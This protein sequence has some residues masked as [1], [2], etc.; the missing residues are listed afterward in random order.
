MSIFSSIKDKIFGHKEESVATPA[1]SAAAPVAVAEAAPIAVAPITPPAIE[2]DVAEVVAHMAAQHN[3]SLNWD[4]SI[5]DLMK[6]LN[7]DSSLTNRKEL[8]QELG[9]LGQLDGSADMNLWLHKQVMTE[10]AKHGG[11]VPAELQ[12]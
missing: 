10:L 2:V 12:H 1:S 11:K 5:V 3:E 4:S 6:V 7:L 9:Y 8:A